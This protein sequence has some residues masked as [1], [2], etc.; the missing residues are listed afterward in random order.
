M[1]NY[2]K[3]QIL[4]PYNN[5][6]IGQDPEIAKFWKW[7]L[8]M[9]KLTMDLSMACLKRYFP[10]VLQILSEFV[11]VLN[12]PP[13][14]V[15]G[16]MKISVLLLRSPWVDGARDGRSVKFSSEVEHGPWKLLHTC[17]LEARMLLIIL[18]SFDHFFSSLTLTQWN[19]K[20][21]QLAFN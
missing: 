1:T 14:V 8:T 7:T 21:S 20:I 3:L 2:Q 11:W 15:R 16:K 18:M 13:H 5:L 4:A 12:G 9:Y 6:R 10:K 17:S 19:L